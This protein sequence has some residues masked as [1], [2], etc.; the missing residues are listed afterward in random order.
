MSKE[1]KLKMNMKEIG[2][3]LKATR[4][5]LDHT[6]KDM[7]NMCSVTLSAISEMEKG[8]KRPHQFYL[9]LLAKS[10]NVNINWIL[11]GRG[12]MFVPS[13]EITYDFGPERERTME[14]I[15]LMEQS[16]LIR[17]EML[18]HFVRFKEMNKEII[19]STLSNK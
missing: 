13:F 8:I 18:A 15:Y 19:E 16:E 3:R 5:A 7:S 10:F 2:Q 17:Y 6:L 9:F 11:T 1:S 12:S 14:M 4:K